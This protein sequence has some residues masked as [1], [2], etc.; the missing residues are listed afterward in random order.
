M[1]PTKTRQRVSDALNEI[2]RLMELQGE[3]PFKSRS[4]ANG[5][6][7]VEQLEEPLETLIEEGRLGDVKGIGEA[8]EQKITELVTTG[9]LEFLENLRAQFPPTLFDLFKVSGLG[10]KRIKQ[11]YDEL[12]IDSLDKLKAACEDN[13][14]AKLKG[15]S[16]KLEAKILEGIAFAE[17]HAGQYLFDAA[18]NAALP[19]LEYMRGCKDVIRAELAGSLRRKKEV[20]KD[21][22][23]VTSSKKPAAVMDYFVAYPEAE[24]VSSHGETKSSLILKNGISA[25]LR[26]VT[27]A[28]FPF[29][30]AHFTGSKEHNVVMRQLAKER[31]LKL[32]EYGLHGAD[33]KETPCKD[34]A[35]LYGALEL[36][37]IPPELREDHGEFDLDPI[38]ELIEAR[39][40][41]GVIHCHTTYSDGHNTLREMVEAAKAQGY[42]YILI[43]DHSQTA[44]Y[45]GGLKPEKIIQQQEEIAKLNKE[46]KGITILSGIESDILSDGSLDYEDDVL[47]S[48][49][50]VVASVHNKLDM[51]E[52]EATKRVLKAIE[53]PYCDIIGHPTGRLLL[54]RPGFPLHWDQI[55]DACE[56]NRVAIEINAN[57]KRLDLD[58]RQVLRSKEAG[59]TF[60]IGPD[61]HRV[62][63]IDHIRYGIGIARKGGLEK[64]DVIGTYTLEELMAWR[65]SR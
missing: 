8:L 52:D 1:N 53:N 62:E 4:Y 27:D 54:A 44:A 12:G 34:E 9:K 17:Q 5:A 46:I 50:L 16:G 58:W 65:K 14:L 31:G 42:E 6:R 60:S 39:D 32:N 19:L 18:E 63:T 64:E 47:K 11:F 25:D 10:A 33:G 3:N 13:S 15:V 49:D 56:A 45:A 57:P 35:D 37:F 48:F 24:R 36:E 38:P 23:I 51:D 7:I 59:I 29:A 26:V 43:T 22:D 28:Q 55:F 40:M 20:V 21:I 41:R 30:L 61:A 2:S